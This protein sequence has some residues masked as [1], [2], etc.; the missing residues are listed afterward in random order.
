MLSTFASIIFDAVLPKDAIAASEAC[1]CS[2]PPRHTE[3]LLLHFPI[4]A[5]L[6]SIK[7]LRPS[8]GSSLFP[9]S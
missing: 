6:I 1:H 2:D 3:M 9:T 4:P 8:I 5:S 7:R